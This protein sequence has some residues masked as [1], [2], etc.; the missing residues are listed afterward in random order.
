LFFLFVGAGLLSTPVFLIY[1][2]R[3]LSVDRFAGLL[4]P[5]YILGTH[6]RLQLLCLSLSS[7]S[8]PT[9]RADFYERAFKPGC[10]LCP[11]LC[12][13]R[14]RLGSLTCVVIRIELYGAVIPFRSLLTSLFLI[15]FGFSGLFS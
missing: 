15:F 10:A 7:I 13:L 2:Y 11:K 8:S 4:G 12:L 14:P 3:F 5:N 9:L 1:F 6:D